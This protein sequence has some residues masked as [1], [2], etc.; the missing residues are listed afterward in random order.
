M[1]KRESPPR[2]SLPAARSTVDASQKELR[3]DY[4]P[5][6]PILGTPMSPDM[7]NITNPETA[8]LTSP[9]P[10]LYSGVSAVQPSLDGKD[11]ISTNEISAYGGPF[12]GM[13]VFE[14]PCA[15]PAMGFHPLPGYYYMPPAV[16]NLGYM[17]AAGWSGTA[18]PSQER[19]KFAGVEPTTQLLV[20][21]QSC[22]AQAQAQYEVL[23]RQLKAMD[24]H[25]AMSNHDPQ[26]SAQRMA[27]VQQRADLK[28]MVNRLAVQVEMLQC[29]SNH[30]VELTPNLAAS[31]QPFV[32]RSTGRQA[33]EASRPQSAN[34]SIDFST[35]VELCV[36]TDK[37]P[38]S[39]KRKIIPIV[40]PPST[41]VSKH[42]RSTPVI[43]EAASGWEADQWGIRYRSMSGPR[44]P[45][46][47]FGRL[48]TVAK[49]HSEPVANAV[50][51]Q[52][53]SEPE[54]I[55]WTGS[56]PGQLPPELGH[57]TELYFDALRLPEGVM[58]VF[59]LTNGDSFEVCGAAMQAPD[60]NDVTSEERSYWQKKPI[61]TPEMLQEL[62]SRATIID[63]ASYT[64][65]FLLGRH[66]D[67]G[68]PPAAATPTDEPIQ[69]LR[70][71]NVQDLLDEAMKIEAGRRQQAASAPYAAPSTILRD[72]SNGS[73]DELS[74]KGYTSVSVQNIHATVRLP[75][76]FDGTTD[77]QQRDAKSVLAATSKSRSPRV[78]HRSA[79]NGGA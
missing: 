16:A 74:N 54:I 44:K 70:A 71:L 49:G 38:A 64:D 73:M 58:T 9:R 41:P 29:T 2:F 22:L 69:T 14:P 47:D 56:R 46:P 53:N 77:S 15:I 45:A 11:N 12:V 65:H 7:D 61:F 28:A 78:K 37:A 21:A 25:R 36:T 13:P 79:P 31:A 24:R 26:L 17:S 32:P 5:S 43:D 30:S 60:T 48:K 62:R 8:S 66:H 55:E 75:P 10:E 18:A 51:V 23:D 63:D 6:G 19:D 33:A 4:K 68:E 72:V 40:P 39:G 59:T 67:P 1:E 27:V 57:L 50:T 34:D 35:G 20:T 42:K 76:S 3:E 52:L